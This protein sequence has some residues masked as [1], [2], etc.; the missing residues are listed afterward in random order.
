MSVS[1]GKRVKDLRPH[2]S[3]FWRRRL[4]LSRAQDPASFVLPSLA[5]AAYSL[6]EDLGDSFNRKALKQ[7]STK[8]RILGKLLLSSIWPRHFRTSLNLGQK[9]Q[10]MVTLS[11]KIYSKL[12]EIN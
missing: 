9:S 4:F 2:V 3:Y 6:R 11:V 8:I 7:N 5:C 12:L 10:H 1:E